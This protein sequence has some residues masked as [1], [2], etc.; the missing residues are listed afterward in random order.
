MNRTNS[1]ERIAMFEVSSLQETR[2][3]CRILK[4]EPCWK[5]VLAI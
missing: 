1:V 5:L 2:N 3:G 4:K